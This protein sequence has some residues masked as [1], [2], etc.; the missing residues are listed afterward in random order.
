[1]AAAATSR[2]DSRVMIMDSRRVLVVCVNY[3]Q[4]AFTKAFVNDLLNQRDS[5]M[6]GIVVVNNTEGGSGLCRMDQWDGRVWIYSAGENLGYYRAAAWGL[7]KYLL[8]GTLPEWVVVANVD[9]RIVQRDLFKRLVEG[10]RRDDTA[11]VAPAIMCEVSTLDEN[12]YMRRR[13][14]RWK[15]K[16]YKWIFKYY[17]SLLAYSIISLLAREIKSV[18]RGRRR[19]AEREADGS[20]GPQMIYA[21]HGSFIAFRDVY[22]EAGGSLDH[23]V[24]LY[25]EE[26]FVAESA[27]Q[28]GLTIAYD[29]GLWIVHR[30]GGLKTGW[31]SRRMAAFVRE[32]STYCVEQYFKK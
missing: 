10:V 7:R 4:E 15:M 24:F 31:P 26:I 19:T 27:R 16:V 5:E 6:V 9:L 32:A 25:G 20:G 30:R 1:M 13:P 8:R 3:G 12:P 29:P 18:V 21:A 2:P 14:S 17:P 23:G 28:L 11:I 22:F